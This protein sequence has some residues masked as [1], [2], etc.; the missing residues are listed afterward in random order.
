MATIETRRTPLH[1][2]HEALG[3]TFTDFAGWRMPLRYSGDL[4]EHH[5]VRT[6]AGLFDLSH[7]GEIRVVGPGAAE[8]LDRAL[9]GD[10]SGIGVGR[11]RYT[12]LCAPDG[13]ILDD[14]IVYRLA[15]LEYLVVANA[16]NAPLVTVELTER[17]AGTD[18]D[19]VDAAAEYALIAVQGPNATAT[20][21]GL[22]S[23]D[24]PAL[25][26]Y[27]S[28]AATVAGRPVLL[29]RTGYTGE[30]GFEL[31]SAPDDAPAL[32]NALL[33][34]GAAHGLV[35]T[36]LACRDTLRLEAGMPLHGHELSAAVTPFHAG[37]GRVVR[38]DKPGDFVGRAALSA[39]AVS[40]PG[41]VLVGLTSDSR[42][43]PR[44]GYPVLAPETGTPV[45]TVT[46]GA[47]SPTLGRPIAMAY[48]APD[49]A[50]PGTRLAADIRGRHE[51]VTV[52]ELP[53]YRRPSPTPATVK[54]G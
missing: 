38:F 54:A 30:E 43:A 32:W 5:A 28:Q 34:A 13:G 10:A 3:A 20:L 19:V 53:F 2:E 37:L 42:R 4:A 22:C 21:A 31:F 35:P 23:A 7:M 15:E 47:P 9:V 52:V 26:Y 50:A 45:G 51:P 24:L 16:A 33:E 17:A 8:A 41:Q 46:S 36:G 12:M 49:R 14:L 1:A 6:T 39:I 25:R 18:A 27:A 11:A 48:V 40:G 44:H 29:A